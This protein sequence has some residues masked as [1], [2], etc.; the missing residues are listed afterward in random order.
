MSININFVDHQ[1]AY[2]M[3][4]CACVLNAILY[5]VCNKCYDN[6][7]L[8]YLFSDV[9]TISISHYYFVESKFAFLPTT[10]TYTATVAI[11]SGS[12]NTKT[13]YC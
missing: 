7:T 13:E 3:I 8:S 10:I 6:A 4:R 12:V 1:Y 5:L 9:N 11:S 2:F